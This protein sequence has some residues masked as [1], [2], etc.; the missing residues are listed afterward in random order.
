[1]PESQASNSENESKVKLRDKTYNK[2]C[3]GETV[4]KNR[5]SQSVCSEEEDLAAESHVGNNK[6]IKHD[7]PFINIRKVPREAL[8]TEGE[9]SRG[10]LRNLMNNK[11]MFD[12]Y[13]C[14]ISTKTL[15]KR[16]KLLAQFILQPNHIFLREK[17]A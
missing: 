7:F 6:G 15:Q 14:I 1:M 3:D 17:Y 2:G 12:R 4:T 13:Y 5:I 10:T 8:K 11:I 16:R 9:P